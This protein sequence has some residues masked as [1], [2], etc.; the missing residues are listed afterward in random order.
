MDYGYL[1]LLVPLVAI[2]MAIITREVVLSLFCGIVTW[3]LVKLGSF[4]PL[5]AIYLSIESIIALFAKAWVV[6]SIVF[7][8]LVGSILTIIVKSGGVDAFVAY[9]SEKSK[10]I[11]SKRAALLMGYM[12]GIVVFIEST[13]SSLV[14]GAV[15]TPIAGKFGASR[16][17]VAYLCDT[18]SSP[19]C[20]L[21]PLNG[22]GALMSGLV[23]AQIAAGVI[24]GDAVNIVVS[25]IMFNFYAVLTLIF[26]LYIIVFEKDFGAMKTSEMSAK[27]ELASGKFSHE[28]NESEDA[29]IS[30]MML[31][32]VFLTVSSLCYLFFS[33]DGNI[34]KGSGTTAVFYAVVSTLVFCFAYFVVWK[35]VFKMQEYFAHL[36]SGAFDMAYVGVMM[37]LAF[38]IG[39][40]TKDLGTGAY[41]A[42][43]AKTVALPAYIPCTVFVIGC[44]ISF[45]TGTSWGTFSIMI[46]ISIQMG[47]AFGIDPAIMVGAAVAGGVFGDHCSPISDTT[48]ISATAA[49]CDQMEHNKTQIPYAVT[50]ASMAAICYLAIGFLF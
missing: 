49:G 4:A 14:V 9:M 3:Q 16:A 50:V 13:V 24:A 11:K 44:L 17:K 36:K 10:K 39:E 20:S 27:E 38:A 7:I 25:S 15:T 19:V 28:Q 26:V 33:G 31:P 40:A 1:S 6:K 37:T 29:K 23:G 42:E 32:I 47:A 8:V 2:V 22:W 34:M 48:I 35:K 12:I 30:Y 45:S 5:D 41:L 21:I 46:P 43:L 18:T